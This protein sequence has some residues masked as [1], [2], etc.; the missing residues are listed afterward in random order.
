MST[1]DT[2][3]LFWK[4]ALGGGLAAGWISV[5]GT[6]VG[7]VIV[8]HGVW[9][10]C[11]NRSWNLFRPQPLVFSSILGL[12]AAYGVFTHQAASGF[13]TWIEAQREGLVTGLTNSRTFH[14][15]SFENAWDK[16]QPQGGQDGLIDPREGGEEIRLRNLSDA[17]V[18]TAAAATEARTN[19]RG[20]VPF[21]QGARFS[22]RDPD[23]IGAE[24]ANT[25]GEQVSFPITV[26]LVNEWGKAAAAAQAQHAANTLNE[27]MNQVLTEISKLGLILAVGL[28]TLMLI[29]IPIFAM[30]DIRIHPRVER[31]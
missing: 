25:L 1:P 5:L 8:L 4:L 27:D 31:R 28:A 11:W 9:G 12:V 26:S 2:L 17:A 18:L 20:K 3:S 7:F 15:A 23:E 19:L 13:G 14:R 6:V 30:K 21:A 24:I 10:R 29:F 22:A 16:L